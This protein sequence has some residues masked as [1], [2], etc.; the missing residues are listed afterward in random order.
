MKKGIY[1]SIIAF[2]M[3]FILYSCS[4]PFLPE[5]PPSSY[6]LEAAINVLTGKYY[7]L[8]SGY[9]NGFGDI[10]LEEGRYAVFDGVDGLFMVFRYENLDQARENWNKIT[11]RYGN[12][13]KIKYV[14][15]NMQSYGIFTIRLEKTDLY[16]WYKDN[17]LVVITG[18]GVENFVKDVNNIYKTIKR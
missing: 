8:D 13:F 2:M 3:F 10:N 5:V 14:K 1:I 15:I 6:S 9:I 16:A 18:D 12:P 11:K 4:I 17:W 7:L